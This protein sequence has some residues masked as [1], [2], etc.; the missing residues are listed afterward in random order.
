MFLLESNNRN[1]DL[2]VDSDAFRTIVE[3]N[4]LNSFLTNLYYNSL[5]Y[6]LRFRVKSFGLMSVSEPSNELIIKHPLLR[7]SCFF[8][9]TFCTIIN[10]HKG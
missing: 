8:S 4:E 7:K 2:T 1:E 3:Y 6:E 10:Q 5:V 9:Y